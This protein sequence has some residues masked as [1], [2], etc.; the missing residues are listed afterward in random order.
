MDFYKMLEMIE[1]LA[2][3]YAPK[4]RQGNDLH[5]TDGGYSR[6]MR[7]GEKPCEECRLAAS[8]A[9]VDRRRERPTAKRS[10]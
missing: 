2:D 3:E 6:H 7:N 9:E 5:G 10:S 4:S 1:Y 8:R